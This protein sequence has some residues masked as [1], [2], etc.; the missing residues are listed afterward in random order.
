MPAVG[1]AEKGDILGETT[2]QTTTTTIKAPT[3]TIALEQQRGHYH[4][5]SLFATTDSQRAAWSSQSKV[6]NVLYTTYGPEFRNPNTQ[7]ALVK[8]EYLGKRGKLTMAYG[9][10]KSSRSEQS[11]P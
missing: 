4:S 5:V 8:Q 2:E 1:N 7:R 11:F 3:I 6:D 9:K 10:E